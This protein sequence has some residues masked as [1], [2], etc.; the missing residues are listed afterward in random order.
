M[1]FS[2]PLTWGII[3]ALVGFF[4]GLAG[5]DNRVLDGLAGAAIQSIIWFSLAWVVIKIKKRK[6]SKVVEQ[7][8]TQND[9]E[10][11]S[12]GVKLKII[13]LSV[14]LFVTVASLSVYWQD[15]A[16]NPYLQLSLADKLYNLSTYVSSLA[17]FIDTFILALV[18][19]ITITSAVFF[20]RKSVV[21]L[22]NKKNRIALIALVCFSA[23]LIYMVIPFL[24]VIVKK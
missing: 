14:Y 10:A 3:G 23:F 4:A 9:I 8:I 17:G 20:Y 19:A 12:S 15:E 18:Y 6:P 5:Q 11:K 21:K 13:F 1:K 16:S 24:L 7:E 2:R 22:K